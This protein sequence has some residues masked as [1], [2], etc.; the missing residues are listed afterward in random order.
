MTDRPGLALRDQSKFATS[1]GVA[2]ALALYHHQ[3]RQLPHPL[4]S[5]RWWDQVA[6]CLTT[7]GYQ[8]QRDVTLAAGVVVPVLVGGCGVDLV[9]VDDDP[10]TLVDRLSGYVN[11]LRSLMLLVTPQVLTAWP[12][13][14]FAPVWLPTTVVPLQW[15]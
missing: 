11:E 10:Q 12:T 1:A 15:I 2:Q 13:R 7:E 5:E 8:P 4:G 9:R 14:D 3:L 6:Q